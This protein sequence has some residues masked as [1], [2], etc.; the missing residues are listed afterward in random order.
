MNKTNPGSP[1][2]KHF[3]FPLYLKSKIKGITTAC[4]ITKKKNIVKALAKVI[5]SPTPFAVS[6]IVLFCFFKKRIQ[7]SSET[8]LSKSK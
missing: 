3:F 8:I 4:A 6:T 5:I 2:K 7:I 1:K